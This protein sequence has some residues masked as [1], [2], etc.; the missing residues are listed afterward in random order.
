MGIRARSGPPHDQHHELANRPTTD[1]QLAVDLPD[2][3]SVEI[4]DQA[5]H[6]GVGGEFECAKPAIRG[7]WAKPTVYFLRFPFAFRTGSAVFEKIPQGILGPERILFKAGHDRARSPDVRGLWSRCSAKILISRTRRRAIGDCRIGGPRRL[8]RPKHWIHSEMTEYEIHPAIGIAR[9]GSSRLVTE[10]GFFLGPEPGVTP[11]AKYRDPEG[12]LKRQAARFRV[13]ACQRDENREFVDAIELTLNSVR[14]L[15]WTV[16][17][18]NRKGVARR[19]YGFKHGYRNGGVTSDP[20]DPALIID[21][22][23]RSVT[24]TGRTSAL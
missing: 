16:H 20:D 18:A 8:A 21:P 9:V 1:R 22:G 14:R 19:Q 2:R 24:C 17:L 4:S 12:S 11:P 3:H 5:F 7:S 6:R 13:F 23:S 15:T 10:D